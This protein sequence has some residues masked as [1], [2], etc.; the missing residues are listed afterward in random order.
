MP[1]HLAPPTGYVARPT[2]QRVASPLEADG[3]PIPGA[4]DAAYPGTAQLVMG[5]ALSGSH[6]HVHGAA[7]NALCH[8]LK[9]WFFVAPE[10]APLVPASLDRAP[11]YYGTPALSW[12][13]GDYATLA[14]DAS[15]VSV[16][17][18]IQRPGDVVWVPDGWAH[19]T[20]NLAPSVGFAVE[21]GYRWPTFAD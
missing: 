16:L 15:P 6:L 12:L 17:E 20:L 8:G 1:A 7:W 11:Q 13:R 9:R 10:D 14:S 2:T 19:A 21:V 4:L 5:P 18:V 3:P